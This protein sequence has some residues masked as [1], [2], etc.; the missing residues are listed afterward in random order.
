MLQ[1][2]WQSSQCH[3][4]APTHRWKCTG[5]LHG[6][7]C[8]PTVHRWK[9]ATHL[10]SHHKLLPPTHTQECIGK[11]NRLC[12]LP[13]LARDC[14]HH[15]HRHKLPTPARRWKCASQLHS[16]CHSLWTHSKCNSTKDFHWRCHRQIP[17]HRFKQTSQL[18]SQTL[19]SA[20]KWKAAARRLRCTVK[21]HK[22][23]LL[24]S[25]GQLKTCC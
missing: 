10:C 9:S 14:Y 12:R 6:R 21:L 20:H 4:R 16:C 22:G 5:H 25:L 23:R 7:S 24:K 3:K 17:S 11:L 18:C 19:T 8:A 2:A 15:S 1:G 13:V